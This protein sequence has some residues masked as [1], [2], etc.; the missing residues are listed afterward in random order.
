ME[1]ANKDSYYNSVY[2]A[3]VVNSDSN[4]DPKSANRI[5]VYLPEQQYEYADIYTTYM[6]DSN[7]SASEYKDKFPWAVSLV[8]DLKEGNIVYGGYI[9]NDISSLIIYGLDAYNPAN[10]ESSGTGGDDLGVTGSDILSLAMPIILNNEVSMP[11]SSWPDNISDD[12]YGKITPWDINGWSI[13][14]IQWHLARAYDCCYYI[15]SHTTNWE[16]AFSDKSMTL[17]TDLKNSVTKGSDISERNKYGKGY[18]MTKGSTLYNSIRNLLILGK[19]SQREYAQEETA[20][21]LNI[22]QSDPY[23]LTCIPVIIYALDIMN[24]YGNGSKIKTLA[25]QVDS[26]K[27]NLTQLNA[28][29]ASW[30]VATGGSGTF[31]SGSKRGAYSSRRDR[32]YS[33]LVELNNQGKFAQTTLA[34]IG[35]LASSSYIPDSGEYLWPL[36]KSTQ[37]NCYWGEKTMAVPYSFKYNTSRSFMGYSDGTFHYGT[38]FGPAKA[39]VD[40]DP[41]IAVGNGKVAYKCSE[42]TGGGQGNCIAIQMDKNSSYYFVYMHLCKVP[43]LAVGDTVKAGQVIGYMGTT[44]NSTGTHLHLGLHI[45]AVWP[46]RDKTHRVDPLPYLGKQANT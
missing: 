33:Y 12:Y 24:Q 25:K 10:I 39:G 2:K 16:S 8:S 34:D 23:N 30:D 29:R 1:I 32:T 3:I 22:L 37:I 27:D 11:T 35:D 41:V 26:T 18:T 15:A 4:Q 20:D 38:D 13:G 40:G 14:L 44:G 45:G 19:D 7:K 17:Y 36:T 5:Q 31:T 43:T 28:L 9:N 42:S 46:S 21:A 6:N